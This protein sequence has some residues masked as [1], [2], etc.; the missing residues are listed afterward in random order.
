MGSVNFH[1]TSSTSSRVTRTSTTKQ[2]KTS[3]IRSSAITC[4]TPSGSSLHSNSPFLGQLNSPHQTQPPS[5]STQPSSPS[6]NTDFSSTPSSYSHLQ[7]GSDLGRDSDILMQ[8]P[9]PSSN[10]ENENDTLSAMEGKHNDMYP[11]IP[12]PVRRPKT[13]PITMGVDADGNPHRHIPSKLVDSDK[14]L[15][16]LVDSDKTLMTTHSRDETVTTTVSTTSIT[17]KLTDKRDS[18]GSLREIGGCTGNTLNKSSLPGTPGQLRAHKGKNHEIH[19]N[20]SIWLEPE[21]EFERT[22]KQTHKV[23][24][25]RTSSTISTHSSSGMVEEG[26]NTVNNT[27]KTQISITPQNPVLTSPAQIPIIHSLPLTGTPGTVQTPAPQPASRDSSRSGRSLKNLPPSPSGGDRRVFKIK[28][29]PVKQI[30]KTNQKP[31]STTTTPST[32]SSSGGASFVTKNNNNNPQNSTNN[33]EMLFSPRMSPTGSETSETN[34]SLFSDPGGDGSISS[35]V[36]EMN[37]YLYVI[38]PTMKNN[39]SGLPKRKN[40]GPS[41]IPTGQSSNSSTTTT[42]TPNLQRGPSGLQAPLSL[43]EPLSG[44]PSL[45][46]KGGSTNKLEEPGSLTTKMVKK[47]K[48]THFR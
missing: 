11:S 43:R 8:Q 29:N 5:L 27:E 34:F 14:T 10:C 12:Y 6:V 16:P 1:D 9:S 13:Y 42:R 38:R 30:K 22:T 24:H 33:R 20:E 41:G 25:T 35:G 31:I 18:I 21:F 44:K 37:D 3:E 39:N 36:T 46:K 47:F 40:T 28:N 48:N 23:T 26:K 15:E 32:H 4:V 19:E 17:E 7:G 2:S 45:L